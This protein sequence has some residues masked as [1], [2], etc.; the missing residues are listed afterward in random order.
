MPNLFSYVKQNGHRSFEEFKLN[1]F[2]CLALSLS[3]YIDYKEVY[4]PNITLSEMIKRRYDGK[5]LR[6]ENLGLI[7]PKRIIKF[8]YFLKDY[9]RFKDIKVI[10]YIDY[11]DDNCQFAVISFEILDYIVVSFR[12]TD[13]T[14][15]GWKENVESLIHEDT[16]G[17]LKAKD[18]IDQMALKYKDKK[19]VIIGHSKGGNL[20]LY[21]SLFCNHHDRIEIVYNFDGQGLFLKKPD[22][23]QINFAKHKILKIAPHAS[24]IGNIFTDYSANIIVCKSKLLGLFQHNALSWQIKDLEFV[25]A[26]GFKKRTMRFINKL[27]QDVYDLGDEGRKELFDEFVKYFKEL[28]FTH[29]IQFKKIK[30]LKPAFK[31][32]KFISQKNRKMLRKI[33][34]T[35]LRNI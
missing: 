29:L 10:D 15:V 22:Q 11:L 32:M 9:S 30:N 33:F 20:A 26:N 13:D 8:A 16:L 24:V 5:N 17:Q 4:E 18:Y 1:R 28:G 3:T 34:F 31:D 6:K 12:G 23:K 35:Y 21:G 14:V 2:D 27:H 7:V 25:E 19:L